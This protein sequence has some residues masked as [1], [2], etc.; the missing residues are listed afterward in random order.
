MKHYLL[1]LDQGTSSSR[2]IIFDGDGKEV[3]SAARE[4]EQI[5]PRPGWVEHDPTAIWDSQL[6]TI[7]QALE[8]GGLTG[9]DIAVIGITNQRETTLLWDRRTGNPLANAIVWQDRRTADLCEQL[10]LQGHEDLI[11]ARTGLVIDPYFSATKIQ[12][13]L[14][15]V[16]GARPR[17]DAGDLAF[18]TV[19]TWLIWQLTNGQVHAT[20]RTNAS[21]TMLFNLTANGWDQELLDLLDIPAAILPDVMPSAAAFGETDPAILGAAI[22]IAGV[23]GDQQ[24]ALFGQTCFEPGEAKNTYGTGS[25]ALMHTGSEV[26][27]SPSGLLATAAARPAGA[28]AFALEGSIFVTGSAVQWLRD[29][30][31]IIDAAHEVE[32]LAA[33]V[34]DNGGVYVVPAFTGLGAPYWDAHARGTI[35]GITRGTSSGHIARA[36]LEAIALQVSDVVH[37]M[38]DD[39]RV[40][41]QEL[42]VDGGGSS[43]DLLMQIKADLLG[44]PV[45][46]P[47]FREA[48]ARGAAYLAGLASGVWQNDQ[49]LRN[50][51][52]LDRRFDPQMSEEAR[53]ANT[54]RWREAVERSRNWAVAD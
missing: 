6:T 13:L 31:G 43:N 18:G 8:L 54:E 27:T 37:L 11:R 35:L 9:T 42:R 44:K 40:A 33:S 32:S 46:R 36:T 3:A 30:L 19:D 12:W 7:H 45:V 17:A 50:T 34:P 53:R 48:T 29:G 16:A 25:F 2:S 10:R 4:F 49:E 15:N 1:A 21:R 28:P 5:F 38:E 52:T 39:S 41:L 51:W 23:A 26:A 24:A 14:E 22:S 47:A 20:D